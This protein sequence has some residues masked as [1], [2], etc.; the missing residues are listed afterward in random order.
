MDY[1]FHQ[2]PPWGSWRKTLSTESPVEAPPW[3]WT[4]HCWATAKLSRSSPFFHWPWAPLQPMGLLHSQLLQDFQC[5]DVQKS[6]NWTWS[7]HRPETPS[8]I[9]HAAS[10]SYWMPCSLGTPA[11]A[12]VCAISLTRAEGPHPNPR[13]HSPTPRAVRWYFLW[14][15]HLTVVQGK[16]SLASP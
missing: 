5:L 1:L 10:S 2:E 6:E 9:L 4:H 7:H 8:F 11:S 14:S 15:H 13:L 16:C 3:S 12:S